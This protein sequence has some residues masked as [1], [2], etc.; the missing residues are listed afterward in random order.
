MRR[1]LS[2]TALILTCCVWVT[3][4][5]A[6]RAVPPRELQYTVRQGPLL[7]AFFREGSVAAH[8]VLRSGIQ[9]RLLIA[10]PA[11][12]SG[13]GIWF[14]PL[15]V[16]AQ[17]SSTSAV[18]AVR[19]TD[20]QGRPLNGIS[21]DAT[22]AVP[23][24]RVH[25]AVL[26]SIRELR[27]YQSLGRENPL[28]RSTEDV[29]GNALIW[30]RERL[31]GAAGYRLTLEIIRGTLQDGQLHADASGTIGLRITGLTGEPPLTGL[32]EDELLSRA[33]ATDGAARQALRFLAYREKFLAGSWRFDTYFGRDTLISVRLLMPALSPSAIESGLSS[34]LSRLSPQGEVAHEEDIGERAVLDHMQRDGT[35]SAEPVFDYKMIDDNYLLAPVVA[36]WLLHD[37]RARGRAAS[38]LGANVGTMGG[39]SGSRGAAL[40]NNM[41]LVI[42]AASAFAADPSARNLLALKPGVEVGEWRDSVHGLGDGRVP[43]D[44][45]AVL[46]AAALNAIM[47][48]QRSGLLS[49]YESRADAALFT[50]AASMASVWHDKAPPFFDVTVTHDAAA[51]AVTAYARLQ[52]PPSQTASAALGSDS[53]QFPALALDMRGKPIP[54]MHSD[55]GFELLFGQPTVAQMGRDVAVVMRPFPAGLMT[56]V[57]MLVAN[58]VF[59]DVGLQQLFT[60]NAYHGTVIWSWQQAL[61]AAGLARQQ[62]RH[63]LPPVVRDELP[64]AQAILWRAIRSTQAMNNSELWSWSYAEGRYSA[65]PFGSAAADADESNAVQLWSTVYLGVRPPAKLH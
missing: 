42:H 38:F 4:I 27:D 7:N 20:R 62:Q 43:Y 2:I 11:G 46:V 34:V 16:N 8:L 50:N 33:A 59:A 17:W 45:N 24:L 19:T 65:V 30:S 64:R 58:P 15:N 14:E 51:G 25:Q 55:I 13:V 35:R 48:L 54:I 56:D 52:G 36:S 21:L 61:M 37:P 5:P 40:V 60:R 28:I 49:L 29:R 9:P 39:R 23:A 22:V 12:D 63:D 47:E 31:D 57:G 32:D 6:T 10:F 53:V 26:S 41:R 1:L 3:A 44:V 18:H